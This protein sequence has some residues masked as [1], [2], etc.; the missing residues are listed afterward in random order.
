[1]KHG[2]NIVPRTFS[3]A[4]GVPNEKALGTRLSMAC[5]KQLSFE[6]DQTNDAGLSGLL[7]QSLR[8][9]RNIPL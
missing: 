1:M 3:P 7:A 4:W 5:Y 9:L 2:L 8:R 6:N